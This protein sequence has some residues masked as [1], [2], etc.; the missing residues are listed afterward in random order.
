MKLISLLP[1]DTYTVVNKSITTNIGETG[2]AISYY[3]VKPGDTL[4]EIAEQ[5]GVKQS[6]LVVPS[7][8]NDV[9]HPGDK[10]GYEKEVGKILVSK[11]TGKSK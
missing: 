8:D 5:L 10:I 2:T 4:S 7:G 11:S 1:A 3:E 6:D 9:I